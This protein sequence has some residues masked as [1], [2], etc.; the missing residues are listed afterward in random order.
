MIIDTGSSAGLAFLLSVGP[1][2]TTFRND[3]ADAP[4]SQQGAT[5][6]MAVAL[7][8]I[9]LIGLLPRATTSDTRHTHGI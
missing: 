4:P 2:V 9:Q 3:M 1:L 5:E 6:R 7:I 8:Q